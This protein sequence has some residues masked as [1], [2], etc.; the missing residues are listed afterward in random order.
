MTAI[1][2]GM[3]EWTKNT[4]ITFKK[5]TNEQAYANFKLGSGCSSYVGRTGRIQDIKLARG[6]WYTGI[7]AHEIENK[8]NFKKY[9]KSTIDSLGTAYDYLSVMHY[10]GRA[11]T[12]NGQPTIVPVK[13]G[14]PIGQRKGI[15][16]TDAKQMNLL[17][18]EQCSKGGNGGGSSNCVDISSRCPG[19]T[20]YCSYHSY[21]KAN[22]KKT[23]NLC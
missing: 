11:F 21:V 4:C 8:H 6:C 14:A 22:C 1:K 17:Y 15:S 10:G 2:N 5:R 20:K 16:A 23:C 12:K 18:K 19:W 7:V 9:S 13:A 3:A